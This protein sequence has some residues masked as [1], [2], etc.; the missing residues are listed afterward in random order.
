MDF[1]IEFTDRAVRDLN[2][3]A[4]Y[5]NDYDI[6]VGRDVLLGL[7]HHIR[8]LAKMPLVGTGVQ[9]KTTVYKL[10]HSPF[11]VYYRIDRK[12]NVVSI[13]HVWIGVRKRKANNAGLSMN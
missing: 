7:T 3:V 4:E 12:T 5:Y 10:Y 2:Q 1:S 9:N 6:S 11:A 13:L 8:I